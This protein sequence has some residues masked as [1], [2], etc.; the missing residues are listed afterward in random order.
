MTHRLKA[1]QLRQLLAS[2]LVSPL[3]IAGLAATIAPRLNNCLAHLAGGVGLAFTL[4]ANPR[5][6][7]SR[8]ARSVKAAHTTCL[9][10]IARALKANH[11]LIRSRAQILADQLT[12]YAAAM[13]LSEVHVARVANGPLRQ[14]QPQCTSAAVTSNAWASSYAFA[15]LGSRITC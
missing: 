11:R 10:V 3:P 13:R 7:A 8:C 12:A 14:H 6:I 5:A 9:V 15:A 1:K 4:P 2:L